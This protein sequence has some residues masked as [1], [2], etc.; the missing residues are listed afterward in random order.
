MIQLL[1]DLDD[2]TDGSQRSVMIPCDLKS[3]IPIDHEYAII[4]TFPELGIWVHDDIWKLNST[5]DEI[6]CENPD[7]TADYLGALVDASGIVNFYD[8][9][10]LRRVKE[11]DFMFADITN[12]DYD[13]GMYGNAA[14]YILSEHGIPFFGTAD[15][16]KSHALV[17]AAFKTC[18]ARNF[19]D[20][21][22]IWDSYYNMGF[23]IVDW[24][25]DITSKTFLINW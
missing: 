18:E 2:I 5:I 23:K 22:T 1:L 17:M 25:T 8:E 11:N 21:S 4:S 20:W 24:E 10:F 15:V 16:M 6:N 19:V 3:Q 9:E 7:M 13:L 14:C 12:V